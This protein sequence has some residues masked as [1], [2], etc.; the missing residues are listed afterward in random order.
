M[1]S[2]KTGCEGDSLLFVEK[3]IVIGNREMLKTWNA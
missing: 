3:Y 2:S 1:G